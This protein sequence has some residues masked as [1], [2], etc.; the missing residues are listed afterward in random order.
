[1]SHQRNS[2]NHY[3]LCHPASFLYAYFK[4]SIG[5]VPFKVNAPQISL[6]VDKG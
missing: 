2:R 6:K 1:M 3:A 5:Y 4:G